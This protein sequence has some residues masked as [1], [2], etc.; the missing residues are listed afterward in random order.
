MAKAKVTPK[1]KPRPKVVEVEQELPDTN[2][3]LKTDILQKVTDLETALTSAGQITP[4]VGAALTDLKDSVCTDE[5][6]V[7]GQA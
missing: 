3:Q 4:E 1:V 5:D 2:E 7:S 6:M